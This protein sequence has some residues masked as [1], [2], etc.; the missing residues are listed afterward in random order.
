MKARGWITRP[1]QVKYRIT[2]TSDRQWL[3][4]NMGTAAATWDLLADDRP[5]ASIFQTAGT[6]VYRLSANPYDLH[7]GSGKT[8]N[9]LVAD[10]KERIDA[11]PVER[12]FN[13]TGTP[14]SGRHYVDTPD[15]P[16]GIATSV[17][18]RNTT[19]WLAKM[20]VG[21]DKESS[22]DNPHDAIA[23]IIERSLRYIGRDWM[24]PENPAESKTE[25]TP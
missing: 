22:F 13:V 20:L 21:P 3:G 24:K 15:G 14:E 2:K 18:F 11:S 7:R 19:A 12:N 17:K 8:R 5:V 4:N 23:W 10:I 1:G 6:W 16:V 25:Q 9:E